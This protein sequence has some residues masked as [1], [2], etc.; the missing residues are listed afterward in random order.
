MKDGESVQLEDLK[1]TVH[2]LGAGGDC[3]ANSIWMLEDMTSEAFVGDFIYNNHFS[4]MNDGKILRWLANL[5]RFTPLLKSAKNLYIGHG[6]EGGIELIDMQKKYLIDYC[7]ALLEVTNGGVRL[8]EESTNKFIAE[9]ERKYPAHGLNF[10]LGLSAA[11]V[12]SE[13]R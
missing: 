1:F 6:N 11:K 8:S 12:A 10:M 9:M 7:A 5:E 3:D 2:D 4:Y 13:L